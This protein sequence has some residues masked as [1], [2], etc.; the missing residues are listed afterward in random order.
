M[1]PAFVNKDVLFSQ[2]RHSQARFG[3]FNYHV[4]DYIEYKFTKTN[5][6][7]EGLDRLEVHDIVF[8]HK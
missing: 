1:F 4:N 6:H 5:P 8:N 3:Q 7:E 2:I